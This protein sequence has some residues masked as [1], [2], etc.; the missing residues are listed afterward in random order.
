LYYYQILLIPGIDTWHNSCKYM[1]RNWLVCS[2]LVSH[3][4]QFLATRA[5]RI[6]M[7]SH[8]SPLILSVNRFRYRDARNVDIAR[9]TIR[10]SWWVP[11][12]LWTPFYQPKTAP[13]AAW[14]GM[15]LWSCKYSRHDTRSRNQA[16]TPHRSIY[17]YIYEA[18]V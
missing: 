7:H 16:H 12:V 1:Q 4:Y 2:I 17:I 3:I 10:T 11:H 9:R 15:H 8:G 18:I 14:N 5:S 13:A 6:I